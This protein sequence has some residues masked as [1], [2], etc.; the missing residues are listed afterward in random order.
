M[1]EILSKACEVRVRERACLE[2]TNF[3]IVRYDKKIE[4]DILKCVF[5]FK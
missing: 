1:N 2:I 5:Y 4:I 3:I